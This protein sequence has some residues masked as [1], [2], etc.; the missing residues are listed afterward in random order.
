MKRCAASFPHGRLWAEVRFLIPTLHSSSALE[1]L[2]VLVE[3][4]YGLKIERLHLRKAHVATAL[5]AIQIVV[6]AKLHS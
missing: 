4:A 1:T 2:G 3:A 6:L 5:W